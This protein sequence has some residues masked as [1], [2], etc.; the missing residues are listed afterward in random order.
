MHTLLETDSAGFGG[1]LSV[2]RAGNRPIAM[3]IG[4]R[5]RSVWHY[6]TTAYDHEFARYSPG[7]VMLIEM[8]R[9]APGLGFAELDL[10]KEDFEYKR[11]LH[12]HVIP[13]LEGVAVPTGCAAPFPKEMPP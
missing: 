5:S 10:G 6:W 12:T 13:V 8:A 9:A 4:M 11:R 2:L 7:N 1:M 3:H